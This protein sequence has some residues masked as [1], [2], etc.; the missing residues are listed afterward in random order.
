[1]AI[2]HSYARFSTLKQSEG[3]SERRQLE[4]GAAWAKRHGHTLSPTKFIDPGASGFKGDKQAA[5]KKFIKAIGDTVKPGDIL[6]IEAIDRLSR[7]G[8]RE[9]QDLVNS[10]LNRGVHIAILS[11]VEKVYRADDKNDIG[12]AIELAAFAYQAHLYSAL[13]SGRLMNYWEQ[14]R[15]APK[16]FAKHRPHWLDWDAEKEVYTIKPGAKETVSFI[17]RCVV[18]G[19][20]DKKIIGALTAKGYKPIGRSGS[21]NS[22]HINR[23]IHSPSVIGIWQPSQLKNGKLVAVGEP[24]PDFFP[25]LIPDALYHQA[26]A[27][28]VKRYIARGHRGDWVNCLQGLM[29]NGNDG[30]AVH[31][32]CM[33]PNSKRVDRRLISYGHLKRVK[34]ADRTT[35]T[36]EPFE[37]RLLN[38]LYW[39]KASDLMPTK[40]NSSISELAGKRGQLQTIKARLAKYQ[41]DLEDDDKQSDTLLAVVQNLEQKAKALVLDIGQLE[42]RSAVAATAPLSEVKSIIE[43]LGEAQGEELHTLRLKLRTV[44]AQL[45]D[46]I[47]VKPY[48]KGYWSF[49]KVVVMFHGVKN[50]FLKYDTQTPA[51]EVKLLEAPHIVPQK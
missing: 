26:Q 38:E 10:I 25:R 27:L 50:L 30:H 47:E 48:K 22:T 24:V 18:D 31:I 6:L 8:I 16:P 39:L 49:A 36:Y 40:E 43:V 15:K 23:L 13:L 19:M 33:M 29:V 35:L 5:L 1:M 2:V 7:K 37:R 21:W 34:G 45:I 42:R 51:K 28:R 32:Q 9:T 3:D 4:N 46:K 20:G 44:L 11:P 41:K 14:A 17:F 12:G